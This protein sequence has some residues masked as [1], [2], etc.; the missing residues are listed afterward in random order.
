LEAPFGEGLRAPLSAGSVSHMGTPL[1]SKRLRR[2][3]ERLFRVVRIGNR[4][5]GKRT[6]VRVPMQLSLCKLQLPFLPESR[7][8]GHT[9][10][11][12]PPDGGGQILVVALILI[13]VE[14]HKPQ[15]RLREGVSAPAS[16][17]L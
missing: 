17:T 6:A 14:H 4:P 2:F 3:R 5:L 11:P 9:L 7:S 13:G 16:P 1:R 12:A 8:V 15:H 10:Y